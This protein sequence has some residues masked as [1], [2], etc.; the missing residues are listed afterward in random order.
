MD[1]IDFDFTALTDKHRAQL[2]RGSP[3]SPV[4]LSR[5]HTTLALALAGGDFAKAN[6]LDTRKNALMIGRALSFCRAASTVPLVNA[7]ANL[8]NAMDPRGESRTKYD[9]YF[10]QLLRADTR[11]IAAAQLERGVRVVNGDVDPRNVAYW[12][13]FW[14]ETVRRQ[15]AERYYGNA[16]I[17]RKR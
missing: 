16:R 11:E 13:Q 17:N 7:I 1:T 8:A 12:F 2:R 9:I 14:G 5:I 4:G 6:R 3:L 10:K 15:L